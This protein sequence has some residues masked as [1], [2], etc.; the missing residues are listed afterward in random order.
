MVT[1]QLHYHAELDS[2]AAH[3]A[4]DTLNFHFASATETC[5]GALRSAVC[6]RFE[7][8]RKARVRPHGIGTRASNHGCTSQVAQVT[9]QEAAPGRFCTGNHC[10]HCL[11]AVVHGCRVAQTSSGNAK[12]QSGQ[13]CRLARFRQRQGCEAIGPG[14][15]RQRAAGT[16]M[17]APSKPPMP[18]GEGRV[19]WVITM[20]SSYCRNCSRSGDRRKSL[21]RNWNDRTA[22]ASGAHLS[23]AICRATSRALNYP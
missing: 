2:A 9:P 10:T 8:V 4:L 22:I 19:S 6:C 23:Q 11:R 12:R 16:L 13:A 14:S 1:F 20:T 18:S 3:D 21:L 15:R 5:L 7:R 17:R